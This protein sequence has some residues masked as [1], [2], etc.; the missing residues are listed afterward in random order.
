M[1]LKVSHGAFVIE[2]ENDVS[3]V[4]VCKGSVVV[5]LLFASIGEK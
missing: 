5:K 4:S 1:N 3:R 2:K